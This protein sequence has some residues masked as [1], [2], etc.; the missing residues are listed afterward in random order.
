LDDLK[1]L[2]GEIKHLSKGGIKY[3]DVK[4]EVEQ[5]KQ[6]EVIKNIEIRDEINKP[7]PQRDLS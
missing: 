3:E 1:G 4:E 6:K 2:A 5:S 7:R